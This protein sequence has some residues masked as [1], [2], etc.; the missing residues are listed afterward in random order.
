MLARALSYRSEITVNPGDEYDFEMLSGE[1]KPPIPLAT[2]AIHLGK[3]WGVV[4]HTIQSESRGIFSF[5]YKARA[6]A[7]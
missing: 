6:L 2:I 7:D 3:R 1:C 5:F 4:Q